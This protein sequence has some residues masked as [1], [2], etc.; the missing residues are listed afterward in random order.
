MSTTIIFESA[1]AVLTLPNAVKQM[2]EI[3]GT[4]DRPHFHERTAA[5]QHSLIVSEHGSNNCIDYQGRIAR[6]WSVEYVGNRPMYYVIDCAKSVEGGMSR[7]RSGRTTAESYISHYRKLLK[8]PV[9]VN[10]HPV[11]MPS[12]E[13]DLLPRFRHEKYPMEDLKRHPMTAWLFEQGLLVEQD[14]PEYR[15]SYRD[16]ST[17]RLK[18][19]VQGSAHWEAIMLWLFEVPCEYRSDAEGGFV[20]NWPKSDFSGWARSIAHAFKA[21]SKAA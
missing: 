4:V 18:V 2:Q 6:H 20:F 7:F 19:P 8:Q 14:P 21:A 11:L 16:K 1:T 5:V 15:C 3:V 17:Y 10:D 12:F 9:V 13:V